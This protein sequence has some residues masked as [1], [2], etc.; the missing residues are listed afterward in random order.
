MK[1]V[2]VYGETNDASCNE[3]SDNKFEGS[4]LNCAVIYGTEH[5]S[6]GHNMDLSLTHRREYVAACKDKDFIV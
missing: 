4:H 3:F 5:I 1:T 2:E 6:F